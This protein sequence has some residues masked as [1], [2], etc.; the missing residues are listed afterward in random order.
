MQD[1][2]A[3]YADTHLEISAVLSLWCNRQT[4]EV[5]FLHGHLA[6]WCIFVLKIK[7][8]HIQVDNNTMNIMAHY[9]FKVHVH[10]FSHMCIYILICNYAKVAREVYKRWSSRFHDWHVT[11]DLNSFSCLTL[12]SSSRSDMRQKPWT[13]DKFV[14][15]NSNSR[16]RTYRKSGFS[17]VTY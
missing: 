1:C 14:T 11:Y 9:V 5:H 17:Q 13:C 7:M 6:T 4:L 12:N 10:V 8:V 2:L 3:T 16:S 15:L